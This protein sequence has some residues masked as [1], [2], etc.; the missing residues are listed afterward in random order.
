MD[1]ERLQRLI[2]LMKQT[3][4]TELSIEQPDFKVSVKRGSVSP[5]TAKPAAAQEA[6]AQ[7]EQPAGEATVQVRAPLLGV[8][9]HGDGSDPN[10]RVDVGDW[11]T[12]GQVLGTIEAMKVRNEVRAPVSGVVEKILVGEEA[13]VEYGQPLFTILSRT[14]EANVVVEPAQQ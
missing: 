12:A 13:P 5:A 4:V 8:F 11:V 14:E 1:L 10:T 6:A 9:Y 3:G 2:D 7:P